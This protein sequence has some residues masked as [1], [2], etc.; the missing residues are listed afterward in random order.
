MCG[1]V[2]PHTPQKRLDTAELNEEEERENPQQFKISLPR[3]QV[4]TLKWTRQESSP[5]HLA[6][7][8]ARAKKLLD[9]KADVNTPDSTGR[10]LLH[11]AVA[12][13][14]QVVLQILL[15]HRATNLDA[16]RPMT[17]RPH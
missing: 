10:T 17:G 2:W 9:S 5:L 7:H 14:A 16:I 1:P 11:A 15:Q 12:A 4:S 6:T 8:Y 3:A 13:D